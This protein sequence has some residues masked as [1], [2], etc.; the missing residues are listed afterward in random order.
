[1]PLMRTFITS[2]CLFILVTSYSQTKQDSSLIFERAK[3]ML[4]QP[5]TNAIKVPQLNVPAK[6][7]HL[8]GY[9]VSYIGQNPDS[10]RSIFEGKIVSIAEVGG[11]YL[12]MT[13]FGSYSIAYYGLGKPFLKE[14][15][16]LK[17]NQFIS[18]LSKN[19]FGQ[20]FLTVQFYKDNNEVN[21]ND[22]LK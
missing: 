22:W 4:K 2:C 17:R 10:V 20:Y 14:G 16:F 1:M 19:S 12:L 18:T 8:L 3:G 13:S 5:L 21:P 6:D 7:R 15:N 9:M 11:S